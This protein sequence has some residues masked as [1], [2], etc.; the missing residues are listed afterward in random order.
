MMA[1][2]ASSGVY[3]ILELRK[4][5]TFGCGLDSDPSG[6]QEQALF[7]PEYAD[8]HGPLTSDITDMMCYSVSVLQSSM[9][10]AGPPQAQGFQPRQLASQGLRA[11][12]VCTLGPANRKTSRKVPYP[13][14]V[15]YGFDLLPPFTRTLST[16]ILIPPSASG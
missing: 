15:I 10:L 3:R 4:A 14:C 7:F 12:A 8:R 1:C 11:G 13:I 2:A 5:V 9:P 16:P 6:H